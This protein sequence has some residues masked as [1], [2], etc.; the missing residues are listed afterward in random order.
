[1]IKYKR[2]R[3]P[4][5]LVVIV[6][7]LISTLVSAVPVNAAAKK[8]VWVLANR[9]SFRDEYIYTYTKNGLLKKETIEP[10]RGENKNVF[11]SASYTY[12][13]KK[14]SKLVVKGEDYKTEYKYS[15][16]KEGR[17]VRAVCQ[18]NGDTSDIKYVWKNGHCVKEQNA[19][20]PSPHIY[21][22]NK[23]GWITKYNDA[24]DVEKYT[25]DSNGYMTAYEL[26]SEKDSLTKC[27]VEYWD[28]K[29]GWQGDLEYG[30]AYEFMEITVPASYV[31]QI[32]KQQDWLTNR[33]GFQLLPLA[34]YI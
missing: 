10:N 6:G 19:E 25:Y 30:S 34:A 31:K 15:Y 27:T 9:V 23:K 22:Y 32:E 7:I 16:D 33:G 13:G 8:K 20:L 5:V 29:L 1:M 3:K 18:E 12:N 14:I 17:L 21:S 26:E 24:Q 28:N 11:W 2:M 4:I